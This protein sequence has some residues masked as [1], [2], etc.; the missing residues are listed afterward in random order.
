MKITRSEIAGMIDH[1]LLKQ[2][3]TEMQIRKLCQEAEEYHFASVCV[4]PCYV[5]QCAKALK[6]SPVNVCTV[7]GFPL[8]ATS[9]ASKAFES[10]VAIA[11][12]ADEVDMVVNVGSFKSV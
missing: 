9:T 6:D 10:Q 4:N 5:S 3:A 2:D 7:I 1:T 12:G 11:D 8:G